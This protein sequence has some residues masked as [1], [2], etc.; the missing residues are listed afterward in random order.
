MIQAFI[1]SLIP[2]V[3]ITALA[4][5]IGASLCLLYLAR[6]AG[7]SAEYTQAFWGRLRRLILICLGLLS[8]STIF[9]LI[10]R[11][12]EMGGF[13]F[14][15][16]L[17]LLPTVIFKSHYGSMWLLRVAALITAW[18][19]LLAGRQYAGS[20]FFGGFLLLAGAALA[21]SRSASGHPSDFG[22]LSSQQLAD[23]LHLLAV[24][25][26]GGSL[27]TLAVIFPPAVVKD[28]IPH[29]RLAAMTADRFYLVFGPLL[30]AI[31]F[32]GLY[33]AWFQVG[34]FEALVTTPYG[35]LLSVKLLLLL[36]LALRYIAPPEHSRDEALFVTKFL[37]RTRLEAAVILALLLTVALLVH[38]IPARHFLHLQ[39]MQGTGGHAGH[40]MDM[41]KE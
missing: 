28:D 37:H 18:I 41:D 23:W 31:V 26:W 12:M 29:Q 20:R 32:T 11:S 5:L 2:W 34:S 3:D 17:P 35:G 16:S 25:A 39:M 14:A 13:G 8:I 30:T 15:A 19:V 6:P 40:G 10:G 24:S 22:D 33:N 27:M 7:E 4:A 36:F 21:F 1:H 9:G 38:Q